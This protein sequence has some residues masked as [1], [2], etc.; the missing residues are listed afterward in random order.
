MFRKKPKHTFTGFTVTLHV[1]AGTFLP[2]TAG[3]PQNHVM[4]AESGEITPQAADRINACLVDGK[5]IDP[6]KL[7]TLDEALG[8][9]HRTAAKELG[10][11]VLL[12]ALNASSE[13]AH[14][15]LPAAPGADWVPVFGTSP[16]D[17]SDGP[18][19]AH[20]GSIAGR[21]WTRHVVRD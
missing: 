4:H 21:V 5:A 13:T 18:P 2:V 16:E 3:D 15:D 10:D 7:V 1:R 20:V 17:S 11:E 6:E 9:Y 14:F 8:E 19:V 12:V